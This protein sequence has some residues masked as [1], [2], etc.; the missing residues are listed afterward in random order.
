MSLPSGQSVPTAAI[1]FCTFC[2][3]SARELNIYDSSS[4][5]NGI[6]EYRAVMTFI[7]IVYSMFLRSLQFS[8]V[9]N[10]FRPDELFLIAAFCG[11]LSEFS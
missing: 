11:S 6:A 10:L 3:F 1:G 2:V 5:N 9:P 4:E 8:H 7:S